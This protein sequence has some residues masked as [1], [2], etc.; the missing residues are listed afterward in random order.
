MDSVGVSGCEGCFV[1]DQQ[2]RRAKQCPIGSD[3]PETE[4]PPNPG[5]TYLPTQTVSDNLYLILKFA[6]SRQV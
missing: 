4:T 2:L 3:W 1:K 5:H 6:L